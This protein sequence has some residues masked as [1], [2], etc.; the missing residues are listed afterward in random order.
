[1]K[2]IFKEISIIIVAVLIVTLL[3]QN[4]VNATN[5]ELEIL[6][7]ES[8]YLL[9]I[10]TVMQ[11]EFEFAFSNKNTA[12]ES[13]LDFF[14][15]IVDAEGNNVAYINSEIEDENELEQYI[16]VKQNGE[17]SGPI[18]V[19]LSTAITQDIIDFVAETTTR[20]SVTIGQEEK[21]TVTEG[22]TTTVT[23]VGYLQIEEQDGYTYEYSIIKLPNDT[24]T[25]FVELVKEISTFSGNETSYEQISMINEFYNLYN[26]LIPETWN[27]VENK[28]IEQ[29]EDAENGDMYVVWIK[30][31]NSEQDEIIDVQIMTSV[32]IETERTYTDLIQEEVTTTTKLPITFDINIVLIVLFIIIILVIIVLLIIKSKMN[33]MSNENKN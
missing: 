8:K 19:D 16:W 32:R 27:N 21:E 18:L 1:M 14:E 13:S 29:P 10:Q 7:T 23:T 3:L 15:S 31:T 20:I 17:I 26:V 28:R 2:R 30:A 4:P 5:D 11:N 25:R 6:K 22:Y 9:Y 33:K 12:E 24:Y